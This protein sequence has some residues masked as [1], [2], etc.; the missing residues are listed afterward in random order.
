M[1]ITGFYREAVPTVDL[2]RQELIPEHRI[3]AA[4]LMQAV[5]DAKGQAYK[6]KHVKAEAIHWLQLE[7]DKPEDDD[8]AISFV[9]VCEAL[10]LCAKTVHTAIKAMSNNLT[11]RGRPRKGGSHRLET[12]LDLD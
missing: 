7:R 2:D 12:L 8:S 9:Y 3:L 6:L 5:V 10:N 1:D 11:H 4:I